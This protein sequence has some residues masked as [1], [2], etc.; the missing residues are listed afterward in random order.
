MD[1]RVNMNLNIFQF[2]ELVQISKLA[3]VANFIRHTAVSNNFPF[4]MEITINNSTLDLD[5]HSSDFPQIN[6]QLNRILST[7]E[8]AML[9]F[10]RFDQFDDIEVIP[11]E[12]M[13]Q[14]IIL[15]MMKGF[16][17]EE[18]FAHISSIVDSK[19]DIDLESLAFINCFYTV[20]GKK[21]FVLSGYIQGV[22]LIDEEDG[23]FR[24]TI[25]N[26]IGRCIKK[27]L[28]SKNTFKKFSMD[29][30]ADESFKVLDE[31]GIQSVVI[32]KGQPRLTALRSLS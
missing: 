1:N 7:I 8:N 25:E 23:G 6:N 20:F 5:I 22:G 16:L 2:D 21:V 29:N 24:V 28:M 13:S 4:K 30:L 15:M 11:T 17:D 14:A 31:Q 19:E 18:R 12:L 10:S 26:G 3:K 32:I 27:R 9:V